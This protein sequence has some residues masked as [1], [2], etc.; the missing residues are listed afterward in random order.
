[1]SASFERRTYFRHEIFETREIEY[2]L[3]AFDSEIFEGLVLNISETGIC[4]LISNHFSLGQ[5]ITLK[6]FGIYGEYKTATIQW[7]EKADKKLYKV[8]LI[9]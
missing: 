4:L 7:I 8:G 1:M 6:D 5:E 9:F 3:G 2:A